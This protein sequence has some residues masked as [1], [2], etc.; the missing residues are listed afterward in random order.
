MKVTMM[1]RLSA[2]SLV[3]QSVELAH[4]QSHREQS[5]DQ[6]DP[7]P[8]QARLDQKRR[9]SLGT[10]THPKAEIGGSTSGS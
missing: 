9:A 7:R 5:Q 8:P 4:P 2:V 1:D 3:E 6:D 10:M